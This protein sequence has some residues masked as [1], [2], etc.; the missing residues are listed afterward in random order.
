M[1]VIMTTFVLYYCPQ[2]KSMFTNQLHVNKRCFLTTYIYYNAYM[3]TQSEKT[4]EDSS[5]H[6][7]IMYV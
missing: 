1:P 2:I 4:S 5:Q 3:T 6:I 7:Y